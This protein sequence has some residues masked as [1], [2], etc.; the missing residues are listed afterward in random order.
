MRYG[1]SFANL[2][3]LEFACRVSRP[4]FECACSDTGGVTIAGLGVD[5]E[6]AGTDKVPGTDEATGVAEAGGGVSDCSG[7]S[8]ATLSA[9][10]L[11]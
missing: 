1:R 8:S 7:R 2:S 6:V 9:A 4:S 3:T 10:S 5:V 11:I